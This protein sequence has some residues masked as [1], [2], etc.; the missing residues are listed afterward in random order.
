VSEG[1]VSN[2]D[3]EKCP[4]VLT[5]AQLAAVAWAAITINACNRVATTS[6]YPVGP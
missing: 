6:R 3:Y 4:E 5:D 2:A 1:H